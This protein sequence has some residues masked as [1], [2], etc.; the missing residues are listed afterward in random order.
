MELEGWEFLRE[1]IDDDID[2]GD[3]VEEGLPIIDTR[4]KHMIRL[5]YQRLG[6]AIM[7]KQNLDEETKQ[8]YQE[9][10]KPE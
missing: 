5:T 7:Q 10:Q 4:K 6:T 1:A 9:R 2:E 3:Y 8:R